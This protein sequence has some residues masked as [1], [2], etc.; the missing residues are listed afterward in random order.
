MWEAHFL[1]LY[2][3]GIKAVEIARV[4]EEFQKVL[5]M[6]KLASPTN[7]KKYSDFVVC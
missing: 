2:P 1:P 7:F 3:K 5:K 6:S 4:T